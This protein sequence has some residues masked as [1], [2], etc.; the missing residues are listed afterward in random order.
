MGIFHFFNF[1]KKRKETISDFKQ[2]GAVLVDVRSKK[3]PGSIHIP[4]V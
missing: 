3:A 2:R 4:V 1:S